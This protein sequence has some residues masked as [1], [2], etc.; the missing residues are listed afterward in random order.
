MDGSGTHRVEGDQ[1]NRPDSLASVVGGQ[2]S[3]APLVNEPK[4]VSGG[5]MGILQQLAQPLQRAEQPAA[6]APQQSAIVR[7]ARYRPIDFLGKKEDEP[8]MEEN[9]LERTEQI[10]VKMH[11]T[12]KRS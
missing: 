5:T 7:M 10:L 11:C 9:L 4:Q 6:I 8:S 2:A 1:G 3:Y 12:M